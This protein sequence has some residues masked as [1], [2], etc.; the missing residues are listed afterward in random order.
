[1]TT[2]TTATLH[3]TG[4]VDGEFRHPPAIRRGDTYSAPIVINENGA[5]LNVSASTW[6]AQLRS[7]DGVLIIAFTVVV[8][9]AGGNVVTIS[10]TKTQTEALVPG[11][12]QWDLEETVAGAVDTWA[13]GDA[14]V[15]PDISRTDPP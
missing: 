5:P 6:R 2:A 3:L 8:T 13:G 9:G 10:L 14:R 7:L 12:Y 4:R 1:M 11:N 15:D